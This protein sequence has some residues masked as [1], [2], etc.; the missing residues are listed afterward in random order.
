MHKHSLFFSSVQECEEAA[1]WIVATFD[2]IED[3]D[4]SFDGLVFL[5]Y[6]ALALT[7]RQQ[8]IIVR[9][10]KPTSYNINEEV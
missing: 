4:I 8:H 10:A 6:T 2:D 1:N 5:F 9:T 3:A 7:M